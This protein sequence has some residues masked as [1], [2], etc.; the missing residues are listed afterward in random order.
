MTLAE[1]ADILRRELGADVTA[2]VVAVVCREA[3]GERVHIP[4]RVGRPEVRPDDSPQA[5]QQR[6][7]VSRATA[8]NWVNRWRS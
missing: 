6:H 4:R 3:A 7:R 2:R 5:I 1:L 8:Y